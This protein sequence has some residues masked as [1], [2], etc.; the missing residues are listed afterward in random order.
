MELMKLNTAA[1]KGERDILCNSQSFQTNSRA[2]FILIRSEGIILCYRHTASLSKDKPRP[3]MMLRN[4]RER[5][6][7]ETDGSLTL[8]GFYLTQTSVNEQWLQAQ[9]LSLSHRC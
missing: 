5:D 3:L 4:N 9:H 8:F 6:E 1:L 7:D 2:I